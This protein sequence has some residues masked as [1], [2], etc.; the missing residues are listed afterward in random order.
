MQDFVRDLTLFTLGGA[1]DDLR[2]QMMFMLRK[3]KNCL[4]SFSRLLVRVS[5]ERVADV[6]HEHRISLRYASF[7]HVFR[8]FTA[9]VLVAGCIEA[10]AEG[11]LEKVP[12]G[13][14]CSFVLGAISPAEIVIQRNREFFL[15]FNGCQLFREDG[16]KVLSGCVPSV[17]FGDGFQV[18][19]LSISQR[20]AEPV[21]D[22]GANHGPED[23]RPSL[24]GHDEHGYLPVIF[25]FCVGLV[26]D[27]GGRWPNV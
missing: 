12:E 5:W 19:E 18:L 26:G 6:F 15:P 13:R 9:V 16:D 10:S 20:D 21:C 1:V 11:R 3:L 8:R 7:N 24:V 4:N 14:N 22:E 2:K 27:A 23:R 25:W 17:E